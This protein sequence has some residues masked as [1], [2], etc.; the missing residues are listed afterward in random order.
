MHIFI[1][2]EGDI[3][4]NINLR[5]ESV[6]VIWHTLSNE[7][8]LLEKIFWGIIKSLIPTRELFLVTFIGYLIFFFGKG[9]F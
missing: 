4:P 7:A 9:I 1:E 5:I 6:I 3:L 8:S 2:F